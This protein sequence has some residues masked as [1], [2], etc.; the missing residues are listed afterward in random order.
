[1]H[2]LLNAVTTFHR[3][4]ELRLVHVQGSKPMTHQDERGLKS[5]VIQRPHQGRLQ[6][7]KRT[8]KGHQLGQQLDQ[9]R[10]PK[11]I[12]CQGQQ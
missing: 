7:L 12:V 5:T 1:M 10:G 9:Q 2:H 3:P 4:R 8:D 11:L 6:G